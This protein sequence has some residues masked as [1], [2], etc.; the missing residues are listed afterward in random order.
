M[1]IEVD[2]KLVDCNVRGLS[3]RM[4]KKLPKTKKEIIVHNDHFENDWKVTLVDTGNES[5]IQLAV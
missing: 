1:L 4:Q 2:L 5:M 3:D